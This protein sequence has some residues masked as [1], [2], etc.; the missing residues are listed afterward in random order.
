M[1]I[2]VQGSR[3]IG[4]ARPARDFTPHVFPEGVLHSFDYPLYFF[5]IRQNAALRARHY[6]AAD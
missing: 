6:L 5:S 2:V 3:D 4:V 1:P